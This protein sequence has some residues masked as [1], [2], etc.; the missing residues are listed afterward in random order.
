MCA[1]LDSPTASKLGVSH[2]PCRDPRHLGRM[3][4]EVQVHAPR[5]GAATAMEVCN[6]AESGGEWTGRQWGRPFRG[7]AATANERIMRARYC[8]AATRGFL[9]ATSQAVAI[10]L[11]LR[12]TTQRKL[13]HAVCEERGR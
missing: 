1:Q 13:R 9:A 4:L 7:H 12:H 8:H 5:H 3:Q 10:Y 11:G 6:R 2:C